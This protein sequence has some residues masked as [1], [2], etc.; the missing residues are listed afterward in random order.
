MTSFET[1]IK[2]KNA[3]I[4]EISRLKKSGKKIVHCHGCFDL[5]HP[6][7]IRHL[8]FAKSQGDVLVVTI[9]G[10]KFVEKTYM[11][12]LITSSLR[13]KNLA[14][15]QD[16]DFVCINEEYTADDLIQRIRPD[17]YIKGA[18]YSKERKDHP[19]FLSEKK[20]IEQYESK[21]KE[22]DEIIE[23]LREKLK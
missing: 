21:L 9:T 12:P 22:K 23:M 14:A 18:E 11:N 16:V 6:G 19:G 15:I 1:K 3:L 20:L 17:I 10:D 5:I 7:H 8:N 13:A 2:E 4:E